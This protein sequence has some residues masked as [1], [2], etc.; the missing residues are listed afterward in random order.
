[1]PP[2][3]APELELPN[4]K[5]GVQNPRLQEPRAAEPESP[6]WNEQPK[7][8][9]ILRDELLGPIPLRSQARLAQT[10]IPQT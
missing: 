7:R 4:P 10:I 9:P 6:P 2:P 3:P 1:M 5:H 8:A